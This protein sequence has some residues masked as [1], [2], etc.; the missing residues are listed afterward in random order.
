MTARFPSRRSILVL[1]VLFALTWFASLDYRKL[2]KP[3]EGR[4]AE[5]AREMALS[6]DWITP[7]LNA[8]KYFEKPPLQYWATAAAFKTFGEGEW[9]ARLWSGLTGFAGVLLAWFAGR[10]LFGREAGVL[11]AAVLGSSLL[12]LTIGHLNTL[13]M[14]LAF[15]L[16]LAVCAFLLAQAPP[17]GAPGER[18]WMWVAWAAT[19]LAVLS[20][21]LVALVLPGTALLLY[22]LLTR[23]FAPWRRLHPLSGLLVFLVIVA[24]WF[25]AVSLQNPEFARFFFIHEHFERFL[26]TAHRRHQPWWYFVPVLLVGALPWTFLALRAAAASW[27]RGAVE[28]LRPQRFL[29]LWAVLV[30][31][32]FSASGS[33]LPSYVLPVFPALAL[34]TGSYLTR[35]GR[36]ELVAHVA[37]V[38]V[39]AAAALAMLPL[40]S[41]YADTETPRDMIEAYGRWLAAAAALWLAATLCALWLAH[42]GR[43]AH[44]ALALAAGGTVAASGI[45]MGHDS[46]AR[47]NSAYHIAREIRDR[48]PADAPLYAV[49]MYDQT[50]PFYL[51]RTLTLVDY[52]DEMGFGLDQEPHRGVPTLDEFTQRWRSG[53]TAWAVM[54]PGRYQQLAA[55]GL[56][57]RVQ[58]RDTRRVIV[59]TP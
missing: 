59:S 6:G 48:L 1:F 25:I 38:A 8:V 12:Y 5:I 29:L 14:G 36:G 58:A 49:Q 47:S 3:D 31:A 57:M 17:A 46:L 39:I 55:A 26:S 7:R 4:Y 54:D 34:L 50:L 23:D 27:H 52:R 2:I 19:A 51:K 13:D 41:R 32:F 24:P 44:A 45:L 16:H 33:K 53:E 40:I 37:V 56:P 22:S 43:L 9:T 35:V 15:F 30:F 21:G 20:K 10:R 18:G 11:G 28:A 42:R